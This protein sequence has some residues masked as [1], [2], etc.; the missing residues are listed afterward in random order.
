MAKIIPITEHFQHFLTD[1]K[2]S[3]WGDLHGQIQR[4]GKVFRVAVGTAARPVFR[5]G[6]LRKVARAASL[7]WACFR[8]SML[9]DDRPNHLPLPHHREARRRRNGCGLDKAEDSEL[10]RFVA[11]GLLPEDVEKDA[12]A[13]ERF[14]R[15][16]RAGR[17][18]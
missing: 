11:L 15:E 12:Q 16:A 14:R 7:T 2:E 13:L 9:A 6:M 5:G 8:H 10:G 17:Q 18:L 4:S 3:F 1:L